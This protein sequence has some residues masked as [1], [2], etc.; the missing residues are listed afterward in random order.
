MDN[1]EYVPMRGVVKDVQGRLQCYKQDWLSGFTAGFRIL[2]PTA[3]IFFALVVPVIAF[4]EQL[5]QQT[6]GLLSCTHTLASTAICGIIQSVIGGQ[7]LVIIGVAEPTVLMYYYLYSF[8][9]DREDLGPSH[10]LGW[11][12]W[13]CTW[14]S[15]LLVMMAVFGL[16]S[17]T[18]KLTRVA[19]ELLGVLIALMFMKEAIKGMVEEFHTPKRLDIENGELPFSWRSTNGMFGLILATGLLFTALKTRKARSWRYGTGW[20]RGIV[21]DY[22]VPAMLLFWTG[23][24]YIPAEAYPEG[25]PKR[26]FSPVAW[27]DTATQN[28][29]VIRDMAKVPRIHI[30]SAFIPAVMFACLFFFEHNVAAKMAQQREYNL[31]NPPSYHYDFL[32]LGFMVLICGLLGL[33]PSYAVLPQSPMHTRS[34]ATLK[35]SILRK[36]MLKSASTSI[37]RNDTVKEIYDKMQ[38]VFV[39][40]DLP[41]SPNTT[42]SSDTALKDIRELMNLKEFRDLQNPAVNYNNAETFPDINGYIFDPKKHIDLLLPV[43]VNEQRLTNLLQSL[44]MGSCVFLM[45]IIRKMPISVLWGYFAYLAIESLPGN[46]FCERIL[47]IFISPSRRYRVLEDAHASYVENVPFDKITMFTVFQL[48]YLLICFGV[49]WIP[50]GGC[51]FTV[52][53]TLILPIRQ[54]ILPMF[55]DAEQLEELDASEYDEAPPIPHEQAVTEAQEQG[56]GRAESLRMK[57]DDA[58][59]LGEITTRGRVELKVHKLASSPRPERNVTKDSN[60]GLSQRRMGN[61]SSSSEVKPMYE[62]EEE[63]GEETIEL[64]S[65][66]LNN[67]PLSTQSEEEESGGGS[68]RLSLHSFIGSSRRSTTS[69]TTTKTI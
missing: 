8:A 46:Q 39:N 32:L 53:L 29:T 59:I 36:K 42:L 31:K 64:P 44:L 67:R 56:L 16:C 69:T 9:K 63:E 41:V 68:A 25:V 15:I 21:A 12:S 2:N 24:S 20:M 4:G 3:Y 30:L 22:G 40:I 55:F 11:T 13:I 19:E 66:R 5:N 38:E 62:E 50:I 14:T 23:I 7:P 18:K 35:H 48:T 60:L 51:V 37:T 10:F 33:P 47:L 43:R 49:T 34:L 27:H 6:D 52:L 28:W 61:A 17:L 58:E 1:V 54:Y 26:L 65:M 45:P 57:V